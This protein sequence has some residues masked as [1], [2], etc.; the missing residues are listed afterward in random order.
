[1]SGTVH[2]F[3]R[4]RPLRGVVRPPLT[5]GA[6]VPSGPLRYA[7]NIIG[8]NGGPVRLSVPSVERSPLFSLCS[9]WTKE[10]EGAWVVHSLTLRT[11]PGRSPSDLRLSVSRRPKS[12]ATWF[13]GITIATAATALSGATAA[14]QSD[15]LPSGAVTSTRGSPALML[16][17]FGICTALHAFSSPE[18]CHNQTDPLNFP[19]T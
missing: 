8:Q 17:I 13:A 11:S 15:L 14:T 5:T 12:T 6:G 9:R 1:M 3:A 2:L 18:V 19:M 16:R 10:W 4:G 7:V